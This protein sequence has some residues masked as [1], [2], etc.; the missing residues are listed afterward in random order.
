M[1]SQTPVYLA[2]LSPKNIRGRVVGI[3]Q[4]SIEWGIL[5]MY[6][7]SY[8]CT[9]IEGPASFR[10][11][12]GIQGIPAI[13]F[14]V[15]LLFFPESPRWYASKD[16]WEEALDVLA[17]L[18]GNGDINNPL[19][20]AE[21]EE[22]RETQALAAQ[23]AAMSWLGLF[24]P[25]MWRRTTYVSITLGLLAQKTDSVNPTGLLSPPRSGNSFS[26]ETS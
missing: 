25:D 16:R 18:H 21:Y 4:W 3:Q 9:K 2:E 17:L 10:T 26:A 1:S 8:G 23:G 7:I 5:I 14:I 24:G 12:W 6:L 20:Q 19:V 11:A 13:V 22:V 15:V